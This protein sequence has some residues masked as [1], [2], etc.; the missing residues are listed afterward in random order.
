M[1]LYR[2]C[3]FCEIAKKQRVPQLRTPANSWRPEVLPG[4]VI[5]GDLC[6]DWH[7]SR[8]QESVALIM[9]DVSSGLLFVKALKG[10]VPDGVKAGLIEFRDLLL[11][12]RDRQGMPLPSRPWI[13][14]TDRGGEFVATGGH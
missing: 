8:E 2:R 10:K 4:D 12:Y 11:E 9:R 13:L 14:H 3:E 7:P 6:T 1:E 5:I